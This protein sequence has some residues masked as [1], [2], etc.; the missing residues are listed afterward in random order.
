MKKEKDEMWAVKFYRI[1][2]KPLTKLLLHTPLTAN[3]ISLTMICFGIASAIFFIMNSYYLAILYLFI[4]FVL[5]C[6]DGEVARAKNQQ[7][8]RGEYLDQL[9]HGIIHPLILFSIGLGLSIK[10][11]SITFFLAGSLAAFLTLLIMYLNLSKVYVKLKSNKKHVATTTN[12]LKEDIQN[13]FKGK[14]MQII[15]QVIKSCFDVF[16]M[17]VLFFIILGAIFFNV[18]NWF[19]I[20]YA[21][22]LIPVTL[23]LIALHIIFSFGDKK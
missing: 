2:S 10:F 16:D 14:L 7:S 8:L 5:D 1:F 9:A 13:K 4:F 12:E 19:I 23:L 11:N 17:F 18:L 3:Q 22:L 21:L 20:I 6:S 15:I